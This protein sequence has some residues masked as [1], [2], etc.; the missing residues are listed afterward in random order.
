MKNT[1]KEIKAVFTATNRN[2]EEIT[3]TIER[4]LSGAFSYGDR[5]SHYF[6]VNDK[7]YR[8]YDSRYDG[9]PTEKDKWLNEI[10]KYIILP[11][12]YDGDQY[13]E[14]RNSDDL[15][16]ISYDEKIIEID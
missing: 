1:F 8:S 6:Y 5:S 14:Q 3:I 13:N 2:N 15:K 11:E 7:L 10:K 4:K 12:F 16:L 9:I